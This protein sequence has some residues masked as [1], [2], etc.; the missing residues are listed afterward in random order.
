MTVLGSQKCGV[1]RGPHLAFPPEVRHLSVSGVAALRL[2][3]GSP[4]VWAEEQQG[5][6]PMVRE[7]PSPVRPVPFF[8]MFF[9]LNHNSLIL[10]KFMF[11]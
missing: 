11:V 5:L 1:S 6:E 2:K 10:P 8:T 9:F 3:G 4:G 7:R